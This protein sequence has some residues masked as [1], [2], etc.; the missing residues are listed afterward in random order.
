MFPK[1]DPSYALT[2]AREAAMIEASEA[3]ASAL[4][5]SGMTRAELARAL[6]VNPSEITARLQ[7]ERNITVRKLAE[8]I[9]ALGGRLE[10][11]TADLNKASS[12]AVF[13]SW[14]RRSVDRRSKTPNSPSPTACSHHQSRFEQFRSSRL[15]AS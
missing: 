7:G 15:L 1:T 2:Y 11:T 10:I 14:V 12:N 9:H 3:I 13:T 8:T 4:E 5:Q 6:D